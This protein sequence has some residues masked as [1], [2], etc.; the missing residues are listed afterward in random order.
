MS[1]CFLT[2]IKQKV[3]SFFLVAQDETRHDSLFLALDEALANT[4][5]ESERK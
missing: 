3:F 4:A 1:K 5:A 2:D